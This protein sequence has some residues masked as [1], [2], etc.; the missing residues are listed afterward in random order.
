[1]KWLWILAAFAGCIVAALC[2][3]K[4]ERGEAVFG[5]TLVRLFKAGEDSRRSLPPSDDRLLHKT[6][7]DSNR[8]FGITFS[9]NGEWVF[10]CGSDGLKQ[11]D[12]DSYEL[13]H[14]QEFDIAKWGHANP[15]F[16]VAVDHQRPWV[17]FG[18]A[19][20]DVQIW[21][22]ET[23]KV[24]DTIPTRSRWAKSIP[25][26][27]LSPNGRILA[28]AENGGEN[29]GQDTQDDFSILLWDVENS[30]VLKRL[31]G[32]GHSVRCLAF[33]PD[34]RRLYCDGNSVVWD[35]ESGEIVR[36]KGRLDLET[37]FRGIVEP[38]QGR[39]FFHSA[40]NYADDVVR[41]DDKPNPS[42]TAK[43]LAREE[44]LAKNE[45]FL[46]RDTLFEGA[47]AERVTSVQQFGN[48]MAVTTAAVSPDGRVIVTGGDGHVRRGGLG[49]N[50]DQSDRNLCWW[51]LSD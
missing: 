11:W 35:I 8:V 42:S 46:D 24:V 39:A 19:D 23:R 3:V 48:G 43:W 38:R 49:S 32:H 9:P 7:G 16:A 1:M 31:T 6:Q 5:R 12:N 40:R 36:H 10:T 4:T 37:N 17:Y 28:V 45:Y 13:V 21:D 33:F 34:S 20:Q 27:A 2:F 18:T 47:T 50:D 29:K 25:S 22:F 30:K 26:L 51:K 14:Q 41:D 15:V 44:L